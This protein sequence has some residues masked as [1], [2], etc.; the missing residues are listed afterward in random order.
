M[1]VDDDV[2]FIETT[3]VET[4]IGH[5][6]ADPALLLAAACY[7]GEPDGN[8]SRTLSNPCNAFNLTYTGST[9]TASAPPAAELGVPGSTARTSCTAPS[10]HERPSYA[11]CRGTSAR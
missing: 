8:W 6:R 11:S 3:S 1:I 5:L 10:S 9:V 4:L 7:E 2:E